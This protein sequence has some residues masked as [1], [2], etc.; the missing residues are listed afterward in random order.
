MRWD[1][2]NLDEVLV[3]MCRCVVL[4]RIF[5]SMERHY[6]EH[7]VNFLIGDSN[8]I[9]QCGDVNVHI[10]QRHGKCAEG[11]AQCKGNGGAQRGHD[12][13]KKYSECRKVH[14]IAA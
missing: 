10:M 7:I 1:G 6:D 13:K 5:A 9:L 8:F 4:G 12:L 2:R 14:I 3:V 11:D